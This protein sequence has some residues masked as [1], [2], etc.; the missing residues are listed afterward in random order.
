MKKISVVIIAKNEMERISRAICSVRN[1]VDEVL[2]IDGGSTDET[3]EVSSSLGARVIENPWPGY[4]AQRNFGAAAAANDWIFMLDS[5]EELDE[6]IVK[7]IRNFETYTVNENEVFAFWRIGDFLGVMLP[8]NDGSRHVRLYNRLNH[9]YQDVH[10]HETVDAADHQIRPIDGSIIHHG[11]RSIEDHVNRF[12][13]YTDLD[14]ADRFLRHEPFSLF[15]FVLKPP[16]RFV[17]QMLYRGL[18]RRGL[19]GVFVSLL[20]VYYDILVQMKLYELN[21]KADNP[22]AKSSF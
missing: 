15:L 2:V 4:A 20:W 10:V 21:G 19:I 18:W 14:A 5:D 6:I 11:F 3:V 12:N 7:F 1:H 22:S 13:K 9:R 17:H 8:G 16:A